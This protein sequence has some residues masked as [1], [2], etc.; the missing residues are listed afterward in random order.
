MMAEQNRAMGV[1]DVMGVPSRVSW[2]AILGGAV[3]SVASYLVLTF[4][5]A[6]LGLSLS[7]VGVRGDAVSITMIVIALLI[8]AVSLFFGGWTATQLSVG[9]TRRE[10]FI[11]GVL[12][13][14][15]FTG[16]SLM[17]VGIGVRAGY[18]AL[19]GGTMIVDQNPN[20]QSRNWEQ[21]A[22][23][24]GVSQTQIEEAK[25]S[26]DPAKVAAAVKNPENQQ[27]AQTAGMIGA[28]SLFLGTL[29][30]IATSV[31]GA[32]VGRGSHYRLFA[33]NATRTA[34]IHS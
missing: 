9:E 33:G 20:I 12:L 22:R 10:A 14:A 23:D 28:W 27:Q 18:T 21:L 8:L 1:E 17:M 30:A 16:F 26:A 32:M 34:I 29:I 11:Y 2:S 31:W 6:A 25:R 24:A 5:A 13:W 19:I 3:I 7:E 4:F 15:V